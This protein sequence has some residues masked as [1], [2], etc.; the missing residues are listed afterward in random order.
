MSMSWRTGV[1]LGF[2]CA[3]CA[4]CAMAPGAAAQ[5]ARPPRPKPPVEQSFKFQHI[6]AHTL[7][8]GL[9]VLLVEDHSLPLVAVRV[10]LGVDSTADP[11]G[12]E[13][14]Y[15]VTLG[16]MREGTTTRTADQLAEAFGE[17]GAAVSP[18]GFTMLSS[19]FARA[20][21]LMGDMLVHPAF[22][23][24]AV[25]RRKALQ[26]GAAAR[27]AQAPVTA[28]R[29]IFYTELYGSGDGYVRSLRPT[30]TSI[31]AITRS[32]VR[33]FYAQHVAPAGTTVIVAGDVTDGD[34]LAA[35][36]RVFGTWR[37]DAARAA[38][39]PAAESADVAISRGTTIYLHDAPG[40][41]TYLY[42]GGR[43]P[44]RA[45]HDAGAVD[46]MSAVAASRM[47]QTLRDKRSFMY[48]G[49]MGLVW[50]RPPRAP[51][52]VGSTV[53]NAAKVDSALA[54][55]LSLL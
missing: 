37:S 22:D 23:S 39:R 29:Q 50:Q 49:N 19:G 3:A 15:A 7:A 48:S 4:A 45:D 26:T 21:D 31:G 36:T 52:L 32:D 51:A 33:E 38:Q 34:V 5:P 54:A 47:Q 6:K 46:I 55:W 8:N 41:Q 44:A 25:E 43:A 35:A 24:A 13:G 9:R 10:V 14:L 40:P 28:P 27:L 17:L 30:L 20:L 42:V 16:A 11:A 18:I 12:R 2:A 53:V 1:V